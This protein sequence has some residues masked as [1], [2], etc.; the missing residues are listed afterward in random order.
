M[1]SAPV[2]CV[3]LLG[4]LAAGFAVI[5]LIWVWVLG[6]FLKAPIGFKNTETPDWYWLAVGGTLLCGALVWIWKT[7]DEK[8]ERLLPTLRCPSCSCYDS[9][10]ES[11]L[12]QHLVHE[13]KWS[14]LA[15]SCWLKKLRTI[16]Y[17]E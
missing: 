1:V 5:A 4:L 3:V 15:V 8:L 11:E 16:N 9:K 2:G 14:P 7:V 17:G 6:D 10:Q 13:H 12:S